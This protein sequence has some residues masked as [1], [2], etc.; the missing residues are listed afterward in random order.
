MHVCCLYI[1]VQVHALVGVESIGRHQV[2]CSVTLWVTLLRQCL[3][4]SQRLDRPPASPAHPPLCPSPPSPTHPALSITTTGL[5]I[6]G[7]W[8]FNRVLGDPNLGPRPCAEVLVPSGSSL[9]LWF[10]WFAL[11]CCFQTLFILISN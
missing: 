5:S 9:H 4:L 10:G 3:A 7:A 6:Q 8:L 2:S 11:F 1:W